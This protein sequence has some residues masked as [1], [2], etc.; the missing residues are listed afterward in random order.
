M[1]VIKA[2]SYDRAAP[3]DPRTNTLSNVHERFVMKNLYH[4]SLQPVNNNTPCPLA[5]LLT[6]P[7]GGDFEARIPRQACETRPA[8][9]AK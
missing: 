5:H 3:P 8:T 2:P 7:L 9:G 4:S 6:T 1:K